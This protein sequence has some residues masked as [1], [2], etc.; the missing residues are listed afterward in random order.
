MSTISCIDWN[1]EEKYIKSS[2]TMTDDEVEQVLNAL[3]QA[4]IKYENM[5]DIPERISLT[6][7]SG[8]SRHTITTQ[9][10]TATS[11]MI[12]PVYSFSDLSIPKLSSISKRSFI[13]LG[14]IVTIIGSLYLFL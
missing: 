9:N 8:Y 7:N 13:I 4:K 5:T 2:N 12:K 1:K 3:I 11:I 10:G 14:V 6:D